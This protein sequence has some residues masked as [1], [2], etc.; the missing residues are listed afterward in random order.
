MNQATNTASSYGNAKTGTEK[1]GVENIGRNEDGTAQPGSVAA[2]R[3]K[4]GQQEA[5]PGRNVDKSSAVS[6]KARSNEVSDKN[7]NTVTSK[8][9]GKAINFGMKKEKKE[10]KDGGAGACF[11]AG[12]LITMADES[13]KPIE[14][15]ELMDKIAVGGYV[16]GVGKFLTNELH[17]YKGVKVSGSHLVNEDNKWIYVKDSKKSKSLGDDTHVVY[18]LGTEHRRLLIKNILF[19]DYL[20][21]KEQKMFIDHGHEYFFNNHGD[22]IHDTIAEENLKTLNAEN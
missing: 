11:L 14:K 1:R 13:K 4:V 16:G 18:V 21:T 19:T 6:N 17:D 12:T 3:D 2:E 20:E 5:E 10:K 22:V 7:G 15:I 8:K 9:T